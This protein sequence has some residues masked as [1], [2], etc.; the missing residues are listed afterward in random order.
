MLNKKSV[1]ISSIMLYIKYKEGKGYEKK[2]FI[3][4]N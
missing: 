1:D 4:I 2:Y 3:N